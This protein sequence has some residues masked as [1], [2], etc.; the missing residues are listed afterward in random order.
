MKHLANNI[1]ILM[2]LSL[3]LL[4]SPAL[5]HASQ[6]TALITSLKELR[7]EYERMANVEGYVFNKKSE[8]ETIVSSK[9][10]DQTIQVLA[11]CLDNVTPSN[12]TLGGKQLPL[13]ILCYEGLTLLI[14]YEPTTSS[15]DVALKW[16]GHISPTADPNQMRAAKKAWTKVVKERSFKKL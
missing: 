11:A 1:I 6:D 4:Y 12:V 2:T 5:V 13:G 14:Y 3:T 16:P 15:G 9:G 10:I 8:L 7:G